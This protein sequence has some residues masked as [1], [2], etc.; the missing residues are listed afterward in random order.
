MKTARGSSE[1]NESSEITSVK[2]SAIDLHSNVVE[3]S[4]GDLEAQGDGTL[5][6]RLSE[7][8]MREIEDIVGKLMT[9]LKKLETD[10]VRIQLDIEEYAKMIQRVM[11]LTNIVADSV[12]KVPDPPRN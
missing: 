1:I 5:V 11:Q 4:D 2:T 10:G 12:G 6:R 9:F 7:A 8:S 3:D